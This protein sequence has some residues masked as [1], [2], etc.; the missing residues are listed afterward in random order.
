M[1]W[2][3]PTSRYLSHLLSHYDK[4]PDIMHLIHEFH[5]N[6]SIQQTGIKFM[7]SICIII[8][9]QTQ[10]AS[11]TVSS[12]GIWQCYVPYIANALNYAISYI[13]PKGLAHPYSQA[14]ASIFKMTAKSI[15]EI[16]DVFTDIT[17][18]LP[19]VAVSPI[20]A[21]IIAKKKRS[22]LINTGLWRDLIRASCH[23]SRL[24]QIGN[25]WE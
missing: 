17:H 9:G 4:Y 11:Q 5:S 2:S 15:D 13:F 7:Y 21:M 18:L 1:D 23:P 19:A 16:I 12:F 6:N 22:V 14:T 3:R 24:A 25:D 20:I 10:I 8:W